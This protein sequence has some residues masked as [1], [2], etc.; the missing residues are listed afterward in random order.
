MLFNARGV[1]RH[2]HA[3]H[4]TATPMRLQTVTKVPEP[5]TPYSA[6]AI[7]IIMQAATRA[8]HVVQNR[9]AEQG[10]SIRTLR[11][12]AQRYAITLR[13]ITRKPVSTEG[14]SV[15]TERKAKHVE[16]PSATALPVANQNRETKRPFHNYARR[17]R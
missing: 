16:G 10:A 6:M 8:C 1:E 2:V 9:L 7:R 14:C 3:V 5:K 13:T 17:P 11:N 15:V 4:S 12:R